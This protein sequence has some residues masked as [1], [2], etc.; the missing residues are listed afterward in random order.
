MSVLTAVWLALLL[1]S[2]V[3]DDRDS[4]EAA[5]HLGGQPISVAEVD[6]VA[7]ARLL[8]LRSQEYTLRRQALDR[9]LA[10]RLLENEATRRGVSPAEL[11]RVEVD[12]MVAVG[13]E[14]VDAALAVARGK[15]GA[16]PP[17]REAVEARLLQQARA[18][19]RAAF[20]AELKARA[21][22][23]I[24]L[25]PPRVAVTADDD[26]SLGP[27]EAPVTLIAFSDFQCPYCARVEPTLAQLLQRYPKEL[28]VVFRDFPLPMHKEAAKAAEAGGCA[29]EQGQFW[30]MHERLFAN[31]KALGVDDLKRHAAELGLNAEGFAGC[32]DSG[33]RAAEVQADIQAGVAA[34]VTGTPA[35]FLNGRFLNGA[36]PIQAFVEAIEDELQRPRGPAPAAPAAAR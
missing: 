15:A 9:L 23:E 20:V 21:K 27:S 13:A 1:S 30:P 8:A 3:T 36:Q 11:E 7:G 18:Q 25:E 10:A 17:P 6:R 26:P 29:D 24:L 12:A 31:P 19:R 14:A 28:R 34:G 22:V 5:A 16:P 4:A 35:F 33:R 2:A 32:L